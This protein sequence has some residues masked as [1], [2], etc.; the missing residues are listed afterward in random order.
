MKKFKFGQPLD[1][2]TDKRYVTHNRSYAIGDVYDALVELITN[3]DDS[4]HDL[5]RDQKRS[6]DGGDILI[7]HREQRK[8]QHSYI[9]VR[10]K[11]EGMD[12]EEMET[13]LR[14]M[15][16]YA[17]E[18]GDRGYMGRG[19]KDCSELGN[20]VFESI[21]NHRYCK[22]EITQNLKFIPQE[23]RVATDAD[24]ANLGTHKNGTSVTIKLDPEIKLPHLQTLA[25]DLPWHYALRDIMAADSDSSVCIRKLGDKAPLIQLVSPRIEG[26]LVVDEKF[27]IGGYD[28]ADARLRIWKAPEPLEETEARFSRFGILIK[29][30]RA[31]HECSLLAD[32]FRKDPHAR[33]YFGRLECEYIDDL[34]IE[35]DT[36]L[37]QGERHSPENPRLLVDPNR[38]YGLERRHP[39]A[40]KLL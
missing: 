19:A 17:S 20:V 21:K 27:A 31:I 10:D 8:G 5:Y 28:G 4:Y 2:E 15:G 33:R 16:R 22:S 9:V 29:G 14:K 26:E 12:L 37:K 18:E 40:L 3:A 39:F 6:K 36:R 13:K 24:G 34:L 11:A 38:R 23:D 30:K 32:E 35:Y 7:E 1:I 25:A